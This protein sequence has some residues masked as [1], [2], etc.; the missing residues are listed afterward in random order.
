[1]IENIITDKKVIISKGKKLIG[2]SKYPFV[3]A[4]ETVI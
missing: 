4:K 2:D 1:M 3:I